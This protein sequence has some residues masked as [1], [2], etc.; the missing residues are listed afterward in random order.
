M[1]DEP[2]YKAR[3]AKMAAEGRNGFYEMT[4]PDAV[5]KLKQ[6]FGRLMRH[7]ND[8]GIVIILDSRIVKKFY[9]ASMLASLP[10]CNH[11]ECSMETMGRYIENFL[12]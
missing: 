11:P 2:I 12:Y 3:L 4:L 6:G 10:Q 8:R 7:S 5:L 9:G 1:P